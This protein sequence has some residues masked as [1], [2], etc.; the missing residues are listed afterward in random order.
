METAEHAAVA[1]MAP[2]GLRGSAFGLLAV[3][4][5]VG[6]LAASGVAGLLWTFVSPS[7]AFVYLAVWMLAALVV[8][9]GVSIRPAVQ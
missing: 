8:L 3:V 7:V 5:S 1:A 9:I 6:N 2:A 4:Q